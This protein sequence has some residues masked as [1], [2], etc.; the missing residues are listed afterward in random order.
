MTAASANPQRLI[1]RFCGRVQGVGFRAT[2][3]HHARDLDVHGF[4]RNEPDGS[5]LLDVDGARGQ[6]KTLLSRIQ[7]QPAGE[8]DSCDVTW[9]DS[10]SRTRGLGIG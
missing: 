9:T 10:L 6:L 3:M 7:D 2:V 8:L 1:A 5:V 4:V